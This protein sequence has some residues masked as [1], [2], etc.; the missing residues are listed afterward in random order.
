MNEIAD[1]LEELYDYGWTLDEFGIEEEGGAEYYVLKNDELCIHA[2]MDSV[3]YHESDLIT[4]TSIA[5]TE[6]LSYT[7]LRYEL[8][9]VHKFIN[10]VTSIHM[11]ENEHVVQMMK[12]LKEKDKLSAKAWQE[13]QYL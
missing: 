11:L 6:H 7:F 1:L 9:C 3:E 8:E 13:E 12:R 4:V 2:W 5:T 10:A